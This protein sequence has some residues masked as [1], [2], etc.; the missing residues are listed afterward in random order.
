MAMIKFDRAT[1][2]QNQIAQMAVLENIQSR[3][4]EMGMKMMLLKLQP[5]FRADCRLAPNQWETSLQSNAISH[6]LG[7]NLESALHFL[8]ASELTLCYCV[9]ISDSS[10][11]VTYNLNWPGFGFMPMYIVDKI[12]KKLYHEG[13]PLPRELLY[14]DAFQNKYV[15]VDDVLSCFKGQSLAQAAKQLILLTENIE[16][17]ASYR[18][19]ATREY[20]IQLNTLLAFIIIAPYCPEFQHARSAILTHLMDYAEMPCLKCGFVQRDCWCNMQPDVLVKHHG[21]TELVAKVTDLT[22]SSTQTDVVSCPICKDPQAFKTAKNPMLVMPPGLKLNPGEKF[23]LTMQQ[24]SSGAVQIRAGM[25]PDD[26]SMDTPVPN[27]SMGMAGSPA[28]MLPLGMLP[29]GPP[30]SSPSDLLP[31]SSVATS[32]PHMPSSMPPPLPPCSMA[33]PPSSLPPA[34]LNLPGMVPWLA[35]HSAASHPPQHMMWPPLPSSMEP[36]PNLPPGGFSFPRLV[37]PPSPNAPP[38]RL[39]SLH[40]LMPEILARQQK[41]QPHYITSKPMLLRDPKDILREEDIRRKKRRMDKLF[42]DKFQL[43]KPPSEDAEEKSVEGE[44]S[45]EQLDQVVTE[46]SSPVATPA[47]EHKM[48]TSPE[49]VQKSSVDGEERSEKPSDKK[50]ETKD[51]KEDDNHP[52]KEGDVGKIA[53][54]SINDAKKGTGETE[55]PVVSDHTSP[56]V[57]PVKD[58]KNP[59]EHESPKAEVTEQVKEQQGL[60]NDGVTME[61]GDQTGNKK[62][63]ETGKHAEH[64]VDLTQDSAVVKLNDNVMGGALDMLASV[65]EVLNDKLDTKAVEKEIEKKKEEELNDNA[66][67]RPASPES[68]S[69]LEGLEMGEDLAETQSLLSENSLISELSRDIEAVTGKSL[70]DIPVEPSPTKDEDK[71]KTDN[72]KDSPDTPKESPV[73]GQTSPATT[74]P[75]T[76]ASTPATPSTPAE[77]GEA[78]FPTVLP[79]LSP[80]AIEKGFADFEYV[81]TGE[82]MIRCVLFGCGQCFDTEDCAR[83]HV[84]CHEPRGKGLVCFVCKDFTVQSIKW[85]NMER[86]LQEKHGEGKP[87]S[88]LHCRFCGLLFDSAEDLEKHVAFHYYSEYKCIHCSQHC[89]TW[90]HMQHHLTSCADVSKQFYYNCPYCHLV[91]HTAPIQQMHINSHTDKGFMCCICKDETVWETWKKLKTHYYKFHLSRDQKKFVKCTKCRRTFATMVTYNTHMEKYHSGKKKLQKEDDKDFE[92]S[93][94]KRKMSVS[95][96]TVEEKREEK[97]GEEEK[98]DKE[99]KEEEGPDEQSEE[100]EKKEDDRPPPEFECEKC[101]KK[102]REQRRLDLHLEN[103]HGEVQCDQCDHVAKNKYLLKW[104]KHCVVPL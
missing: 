52:E 63:E 25:C 7:A 11:S 32:L 74:G 56:E 73:A 16:T 71:A 104:V 92:P 93:A 19:D 3:T 29:P 14:L 59:E 36:P 61:T 39:S 103:A 31:P 84:R 58:G 40:P 62:Q 80:E 66:S 88:E 70:A 23:S 83:L 54:E 76:P 67:T 51:G 2:C 43:A 98:E 78:P 46:K 17:T 97:E 86:H 65:A 50:R 95:S 64:I 81:P 5:H 38:S 77:G 75:P 26:G 37:L 99:T 6:W 90:K 72:N 44:K 34:S 28:G 45:E 69:R 35:P 12:H 30:M 18:H 9:C 89:F 1:D 100:E 60:D 27:L 42:D 21:P 53:E 94:K 55:L 4:L 68:D 15:A 57:K 85:Y 102:F 82:R 13:H 47:T 20:F 91:F 10:P 8:G 96:E 49:K 87:V 24:N 48:D 101:G 33:M 41:N 22:E 79:D